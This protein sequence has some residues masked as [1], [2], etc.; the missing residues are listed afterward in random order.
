MI[1]RLVVL[2]G[3]GCIGTTTVEVASLF[4]IWGDER[5]KK[6]MEEIL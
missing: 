2:K 3:G 6:F 5:A 4:T 1:K